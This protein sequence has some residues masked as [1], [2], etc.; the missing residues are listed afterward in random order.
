MM[1]WE[2]HASYATMVKKQ[3]K[4]KAKELHQPPLLTTLVWE[5]PVSLSEEIVRQ[6]LHGPNFQQTAPIAEF[7]RRMQIVQDQNV[8]KHPT[9][10]GELIRWIAVHIVE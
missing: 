3:M 6:V 1:I 5:I 9:Q 10:R 4:T 7:D 8:M 2:F